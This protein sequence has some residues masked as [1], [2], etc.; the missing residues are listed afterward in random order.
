MKPLRIVSR[1][2][3]PFA[4]RSE[5]GRL[6]AHELLEWHGRE[7]VVLGIPRGG[8]IV[9]S[10]LA[11]ALEAELDV[12]LARKLRSPGRLELAMGAVAEDGRMFLNESVVQE[13][14]VS[15]EYIEQERTRQLAEIKRRSELIRV[16]VP[17][18][19]LR[20]RIVIVTDDGVAT[21]AT[22]LAAFQAAE[23]ERPRK[24]IGAFPVGSEDTIRML[25]GHVDEMV[26]LRAPPMFQAVGQ[27]YV[28]F[29]PVSD[30]DVIEV[31]KKERDY[32]AAGR[33]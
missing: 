8:V 1:S 20:G 24:L 33:T 10:E 9:A 31:L 22:T 12:V 28:K 4:D 14:D 3:Q 5:G 29:D 15:E 23:Q 17:K 6:L 7:A 26:C 30:T 21:G 32:Q 11:R 18:L 27:F 2:S 19:Q 13:L 16:L 25:A